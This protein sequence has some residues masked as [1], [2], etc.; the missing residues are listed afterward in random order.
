MMTIEPCG[1]W[2]HVVPIDPQGKTAGKLVLASAPNKQ[3]TA[4]SVG[5]IKSCG[6][7]DPN[8]HDPALIM[9]MRAVEGQV[10]HYLQSISCGM[11]SE[12]GTPIVFVRDSDIICILKGITPDLIKAAPGNKLAIPTAGDTLRLT[13]GMKNHG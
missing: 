4:L 2:Y 7:G 10:I 8:P 11:V 12:D 9:P 13:N 1:A 6:P 3:A 5:V